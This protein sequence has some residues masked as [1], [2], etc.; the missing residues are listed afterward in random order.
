MSTTVRT[1]RG[2][3]GASELGRTLIHEHL[4][5][6]ATGGFWTPPEPWKAPY[7]DTKVSADVAWLLREDP[8]CCWDNCLLD[9]VDATVDELKHFLSVGGRS[10]VDPTCDGM[11]RD[12]KAL[13]KISERTGLQVVMGAGWYLGHSHPEWVKKAS[14]ERLTDHLLEEFQHGADG[15]DIR[16]GLLGEIGISSDFTDDEER[17]LRA[18][19]R[20][21]VA[22]GVPL[23]VHLPGW[24][25]F[26]H[27]VLDV[28]A[29]EG[30]RPEAIVL[31]HM[32]PSG[33]DPDYQ[34]ALAKRGAWLEFDMV[35]MGFYY[36]N[37]DGQSPAPEDDAIAIAHLHRSGFAGR[38]LLSHDVFLKSMWIRHGGNGFG[39]INRFFLDRLVRHGIEREVVEA[40]ID[41]HPSAVFTAAAA[42]V[43]EKVS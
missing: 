30:V 42:I 40:M 11:G 7:R 23:M 36:A 2:D 31:C 20:A 22:T 17:C 35:G 43:R 12:P 9:D 32:N 37:E 24:Q 26:G 13:L 1:V 14:V 29:E 38:V 3:I 5:V 33:I 21:Q 39:Y 18:A 27:R 28:A 19:A 41:V 34:V 10:I 15:T 8:F 4:M 25:R 16:P 6:D